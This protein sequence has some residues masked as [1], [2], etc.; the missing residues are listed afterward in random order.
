MKQRGGSAR[1]G[2]V[3]PYIFCVAQGEESAKTGLAERA[4][5]PD[6]LRKAGD[7]GLVIGGLLPLGFGFGFFLGGGGVAWC[8]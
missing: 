4:K 6:E 3:I 2:D 5:H 7:G 1:T 8:G